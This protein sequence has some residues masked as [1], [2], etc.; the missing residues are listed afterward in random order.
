[1]LWPKFNSKG[2]GIRT[3]SEIWM[4]RLDPRIWKLDIFTNYWGIFDSLFFSMNSC[5]IL[6]GLATISRQV[7]ML[8]EWTS[9]VAVLK[10]HIR[11]Y[12][13]VAEA[14]ADVF[15]TKES[16]IL[17]WP[18]PIIPY[19]FIEIDRLAPEKTIFKQKSLGSS[20]IGSQ[21]GCDDHTHA[22]DD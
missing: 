14:L 12:R 10:G 5:A 3:I 7:Q 9:P 1:M 18:L 2:H 4:N 13:G 17:F 16:F 20:G 15:N 8:A 22:H 6:V 21:C 19:G 11:P